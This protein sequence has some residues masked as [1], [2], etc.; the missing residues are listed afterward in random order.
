MKKFFW[1]I[2]EITLDIFRAT[3]YFIK[4]NLRTFASL[5]DLVLPYIMYFIGQYVCETIGYL[6]VG[7]EVFIPLGFVVVVYYLRSSANKLGKGITIPIPYKRFSNVD[8]DGEVTIENK[9]M[10][11]LILYIADLEDWLERKGLL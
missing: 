2:C 4:N 8:D 1:I 3:A 10:P 6:E 9:R 7:A 5:L 11:E